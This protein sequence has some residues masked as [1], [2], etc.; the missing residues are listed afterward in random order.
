MEKENKQSEQTEQE[1]AKVTNEQE[2][3][4]ESFETEVGEKQLEDDLSD[5]DETIEKLKQELEQ[6]KQE[7]AETYDRLMRIQAEYENYKRRSLKERSEERKYKAQ[8]LA[9]ELLPVLDNFERALQVETTEENKQLHE[10]ISMVY[11][12]FKQALAT[13]GIEEIEAKGKPFDPNL[14]HAVMQVE[15]ESKESN[16]VVEELQKGYKLNDRVIRPTMVKV[17]K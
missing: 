2:K 9:T 14:H 12:Q 1:N 6:V 15:D 8:E 17:N 5:T 3:K 10:G 11:N 16:I 4:Q 13:Q 7:K